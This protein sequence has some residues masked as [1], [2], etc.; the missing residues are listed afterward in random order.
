MMRPFTCRQNQ[1]QSLMETIFIIP[2]VYMF[3]W[4]IYISYRTSE[5]NC[6]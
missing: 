1:L 2:E 3:L 5:Q 4:K 6:S